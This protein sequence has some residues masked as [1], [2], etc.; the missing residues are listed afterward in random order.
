MPAV[1]DRRP[2]TRGASGFGRGARGA[3]MSVG[4]FGNRGVIEPP[5]F[6]VTV[7]PNC[8][9]PMLGN[10]LCTFALTV[11][12]SDGVPCADTR[13]S[14]FL[15]WLGSGIGYDP[16]PLPPLPV[17]FPGSAKDEL[18]SFCRAAVDS[19]AMFDP[20][21]FEGHVILLFTDVGDDAAALL[22][23]VLR[24]T[25]LAATKVM[26]LYP[27]VAKFPVKE[28]ALRFTFERHS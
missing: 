10:F 18:G 9:L 8:F 16:L 20:H 7:P 22:L 26:S 3:P 28:S 19:L 23:Y 14:A 17:P 1:L 6:G 21:L 27:I 5:S 12:F 13:L 25:F 4:A 24:K 15:A 11:A 2:G